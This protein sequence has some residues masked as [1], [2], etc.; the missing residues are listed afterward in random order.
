MRFASV[1]TPSQ[2][3]PG[4]TDAKCGTRAKTYICIIYC[5]RK[6]KLACVLLGS[7]CEHP[8]PHTHT[9]TVL[10]SFRQFSPKLKRHHS[11]MCQCYREHILLIMM[12]TVQYAYAHQYNACVANTYIVKLKPIR[13]IPCAQMRLKPMLSASKRSASRSAPQ[14]ESSNASG[15]CERCGGRGPDT[16]CFP[17]GALNNTKKIN[18]NA[19]TNRRKQN[20]LAESRQHTR[21]TRHTRA[22]LLRNCIVKRACVLKPAQALAH[23][24]SLA[25]THLG[26]QKWY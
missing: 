11:S 6:L 12:H 15:S 21:H 9:I 8:Q 4:N 13:N 2:F 23:T 5:C 24:H 26:Q 14:R 20:A 25:R 22:Q 3:A 7:E 16:T 18:A 19:N 17:S 10:T 1:C